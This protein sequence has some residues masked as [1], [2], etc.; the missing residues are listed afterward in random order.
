[1]P[2]TRGY[3][4]EMLEESMRRNIV[5]ALDTGAGKTHIAVLR[6]KIESERES[7]KVCWFLVP[8]VALAHQQHNVIRSHLPVSVGLISGALEPDQW[9]DKG[10]WLRVLE[11]YKIVVTTH[12]ILLNALRHG[13]IDLGRD[14]SLL[15]FDEAH[16]AAD[17]HPYNMIMQEFYFG[18]PVRP[19]PTAGE[20]VDVNDKVRPIILG[21][22]AS[23]IFGGDVEKAFRKIEANLD[24]IIRAPQMHRAELAGFVYPP[25]FKYVV[26]TAPEYQLEGIPPTAS[27]V[28]LK[29]V[30]DSLEIEEDPYVIALREK[31]QR[32]P[33]GAERT[34]TDQKL[35][36]TVSKKDTYTHKGI[37]D[38]YRAADEIC[39]DLGEWSADW[40][41]YTVLKQVRESQG[42]FPE[43]SSVL[44]SREYRYLVD[45][46]SRVQ[47]APVSYEVD[48]IIS[49][50]SDKVRRLVD[51]LLA[52]K[53]FFEGHGEE[54]RGLVFVTR[55]DAVLAL[56]EILTNHPQTKDAFQVGSLLGSSDSAHRK[57]FL[58]I[59][60]RLLKVDANK[61]LDNFRTGEF[62]LII[63]TAVAEEGLDIQACCSVIRWDPPPNMVSWKQ[64]RGRARQKRSTFTVMLTD[65]TGM[66]NVT[67]WLETEKRMTELY[68]SE[69][70]KEVGLGAEVDDVED[71]PRE[72]HMP[73]TGALLTLDSAIEHINHFCAILP[74]SG[75][76]A[77]KPIFDIIP[78]QYPPEWHTYGGE[79][80]VQLGPF[81]CTITLP[82]QI[83]ASFRTFTTPVIHRTKVS[84]QR[85]VAFDAYLALYQ[86]DLLDDHLL[87]FGPE[88]ESE[89]NLLLQEVQK[90][91]GTARVTID[92]M[93]PMRLLTQMPIA[94]LK[95]EEMPILHSPDRGSFR[96]CVRSSSSPLPTA[97]HHLVPRAREY[98][99]CLLSPLFGSR[100]Q[101]DKTDFGY[102]FLPSEELGA[103][104]WDARRDTHEENLDRSALTAQPLFS[105]AHWFGEHEIRRYGKAYRFLRWRMKP[106][107]GEEKTA[108]A[109]RYAP[110]EDE[111]LLGE[112]H[113]PLLE[114]K[115]LAPRMNF[116]LP[117]PPEAKGDDA[118]SQKPVLLI[119]EYASIG[120][121]SSHEAQFSMWAP[122][123]LRY[124]AMAN[125]V[126]SMRE[127]LLA[128]R[129]NLLDIPLNILM[130][131]AS[132]PVAQE[133]MNYQRLET[134]G[135]TVLKYLTS[136]NLMAQYRYWHEGYLTR[137]K[138]H[139]VSNASLAKAAIEKKLY[140]WIIRDR[141]SPKK[142]KPVYLEPEVTKQTVPA[143]E[144]AGE[145]VKPRQEI[146]TKVLADVVEALIGAAYVH[147]GVELGRECIQLFELGIA[148]ESLPS[149]M[150]E[151][152]GRVEEFDEYPTQLSAVE[153]ILGHTFTRKALLVEAL[154]HASFQSDLPTVS[155]ERM[156]FLGDAVLDM[157]VTDYLYHA[158]GKNYSPG[159]MHMRKMAVVNAHFLAMICLRAS[160][161]YDASMPVWTREGGVRMQADPRRVYLWQCLL[162]SS[163]PVLDEQNLAFA[164]WEGPNGRARI[165]HALEHGDAFPWAALTALQAPKFLSDMVESLLGAVFIDTRGSL[166]A[167]RDVLRRLGLLP[168]LERIVRD[169]VHI[170][171]PISQLSLWASKRGERIRYV[172]PKRTARC[173]V[174][175]DDV[176]VLT[177]EEVW[178][179]RASVEEVR[180]KAA[181]KALGMV[182]DPVS[183]LELWTA[184]RKLPV[185]HVSL[186]GEDG[187]LASV[188]FVDG[189]E[190]ARVVSCGGAEKEEEMRHAAATEALKLLEDPQWRLLVWA[191]NRGMDLEYVMEDVEGVPTCSVLVGGVE[192]ASRKQDTRRFAKPEEV[193]AVV[194]RAA[195]KILDSKDLEKRER[196]EE[197]GENDDGQWDDWTLDQQTVAPEGW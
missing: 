45:A 195:M 127:K 9:K 88:K 171:D 130:T 135:D 47:A 96:V 49:R 58:D 172:M 5:I 60:R 48:E 37:R 113:Y 2:Q 176:E 76:S 154:T 107:S 162:H 27:L 21:L 179:G 25:E 42:M 114:V 50:S 81:G 90:R 187:T 173:T 183:R 112:I 20:R 119:P 141:F 116:L 89:V 54:Y 196:A 8:T 111:A 185:E 117:I 10:L 159:H 118:A 169:E 188:V 26:Y 174:L 194:A 168:V 33:P 44:N 70:T 66:D 146:S 163:V 167:V 36:K 129:P 32:T 80:P 71:N 18:L 56:T 131:A 101:W 67:H 128:P 6:M 103:S 28:S 17:K 106:V 178:H 165:E 109:E 95:D 142:W 100:L 158:P 156:E 143:P 84:A 110:G 91:H 120:L 125:T 65:E 121:I 87:P 134:L 136:I 126:H 102:L 99:R 164:R 137:R 43:F 97:D 190:I 55:R 24:C 132:A 153:D 166:D 7:K 124:L 39:S 193:Q 11:T 64:S 160:T 92:G 83:D 115:P 16:H 139:A 175:W 14:I 30:L 3:Q 15:V 104:R 41:I 63:A 69:R 19:D 82:R 150:D 181:E 94:A 191:A 138:D 98:T 13:Y 144:T 105:R 108:L 123:I 61:T 72:F 73:S 79:V 93:P 180:Y 140:L 52:E 23:P 57:S 77:H 74:W 85:H 4:Q 161:A 34:R 133:H 31:L 155:Y 1:M 151:M 149:R 145:E 46:F 182:Q 62:N 22:T 59:T 68:N 35:S 186:Q 86:H 170:R 51:A 78:H 122:S 192:L 197:T 147:G 75:R 184:K 157:I 189:E 40:Y 38:F 12:A 53:E 29:T 148:M 152:L 177:M